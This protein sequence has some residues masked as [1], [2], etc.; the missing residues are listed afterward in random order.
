[1]CLRLLCLIVSRLF[2]WMRLSRRKE[3]W[4]SA[5]I[6]LL[7]HQLTVLQRQQTVQPN[8]TWADRALIA[9]LLEVIPKRRRSGVRL[10]VMPETV[11]RW[12]R[13]IIGRRWPAKSRHERP[14]RP[15]T[16][17]QRQR[18][19]TATGRRESQLGIPEHP[20]RTRRPRHR[21]RAIDG[22]GHPDQG[23]ACDPHPRRAGPS[24]AQFLHG[25]ARAIL[26]T[27]FFTVDLLDGQS[28]RVRPDQPGQQSQRDRRPLG[29][30]RP[31]ATGLSAEQAQ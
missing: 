30:R 27:D 23:L 1:M 7:R 16:P 22:V 24:W 13:D 19:G 18:V 14:G 4:K 26:A 15:A 29:G 28:P 20:R 5:E 21:S 17:P 11:L 6:L 3:S 25:Q 8:T 12:R 9:L 2:G 10:I 31:G